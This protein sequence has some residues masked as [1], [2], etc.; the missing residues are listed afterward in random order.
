MTKSLEILNSGLDNEVLLEEFKN[1][2]EV[3]I[4]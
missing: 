1:V 3:L 2:I 4:V